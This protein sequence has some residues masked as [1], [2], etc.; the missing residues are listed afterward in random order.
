MLKRSLDVEN[1]ENEYE[2]SLDPKIK[3]AK[4]IDVQQPE[5]SS[6]D[7]EEEEVQGSWPI[8]SV[9]GENDGKV[10][11]TNKQYFIYEN[12][13]P[14][15][16]SKTAR[17]WARKYLKVLQHVDPDGYDVCFNYSLI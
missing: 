9:I 4:I 2:Q 1:K 7:E 15:M 6:D 8:G 12:T 13:E 14:N 16:I 17:F 11:P 3:K 5:S 10:H